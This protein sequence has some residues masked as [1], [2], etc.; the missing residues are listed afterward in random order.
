MSSKESITRGVIL[1]TII[2]TIS[3]VI[4]MIRTLLIASYFGANVVTDGFQLASGVMFFFFLFIESALELAALPTLVKVQSD[5]ARFQQVVWDFATKLLMLCGVLAF[6]L[7][8]FKQAVLTFLVPASNSDL[9][10]ATDSFLPIMTLGSIA[11]ILYRFVCLVERAQQKYSAEII[12]DLFLSCVLTAYLFI[13]HS[14]PFVLGESYLIANIFALIFI[15]WRSKTMRWNKSIFL[16]KDAVITSGTFGLFIST[17]LISSINLLLEKKLGASA[18]GGALTM[19]A[20]ATTI[21]RFLATYGVSIVQIFHPSFQGEN[22][23]N[24]L[25]QVF[26]LICLYSIPIAFITITSSDFVIALL[27]SSKKLTPDQ[28]SEMS[29]SIKILGGYLVTELIGN[30]QVRYVVTH[31]GIKIYNLLFTAATLGAFL[32]AYYYQTILGYQILAIYNLLSNSILLLGLTIYL[33]RFRAINSASYTY[34]LKLVG[35]SITGYFVAIS[36]NS[37]LTLEK[38]YTSFIQ[39][40]VFTGIFS[41]FYLIVV[42]DEINLLLQDKGVSLLRNVKSKLVSRR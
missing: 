40:C 10:L 32:F 27:F 2:K 18:P 29:I 16:M 26:K 7:F 25:N 5:F 38:A 36:L 41:I 8:A 33:H 17:G 9:K 28:L 3:R 35:I 21:F 37:I 24:R 30:T 1:S 13:S 14:D 31:G 12:S 15:V 34:L 22:G 19:Y 20:F 4:G 42:K 23:T 39:T 6:I 11:Y